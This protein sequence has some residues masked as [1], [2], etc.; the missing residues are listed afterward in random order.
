MPQIKDY[1]ITHLGNPKFDLEIG[2]QIYLYDISDNLIAYIFF[3]K[4][5]S[6]ISL[7]H[8]S[9]NPGGIYEMTMSYSNL[10]VI[11]DTLRNENP[12][13]FLWSEELGYASISTNYE[14]VGDGEI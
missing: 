6:T 1:R 10:P 9:V 11:I 13:Y 8:D 14:P 5:N 4:S 2:A 3:L 7:P 12:V